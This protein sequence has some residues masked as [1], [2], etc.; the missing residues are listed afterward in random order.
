M[1]RS[2]SR[3]SI[4]KSLP[5]INR[6]RSKQFTRR[7]GRFHGQRAEING[8]LYFRR[9]PPAKWICSRH[10]KPPKRRNSTFSASFRSST[11]LRFSGAYRSRHVTVIL[12]F[13]AD[14]PGLHDWS[15]YFSGGKVKT[16]RSR[17]FRIPR[18]CGCVTLRF[19]CS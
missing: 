10:V 12:R 16:R 13:A 11:L 9:K 5:L 7:A 1:L 18:P 8:G 4:A 15:D 2:V 17:N 19:R 14:N 6:T 3:F